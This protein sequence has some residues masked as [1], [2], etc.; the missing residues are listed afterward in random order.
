EDELIK[1]EEEIERLAVEAKQ[2]YGDKPEDTGRNQGGRL[3]DGSHD[4][5]VPLGLGAFDQSTDPHQDVADNDLDHQPQEDRDKKSDPLPVG[6][7]KQLV[8]GPVRYMLVAPCL[9]VV[10]PFE[11]ADIGPILDLVVDSLGV[12]DSIRRDEIFARPLA[13]IHVDDGDASAGQGPFAQ[14]GAVRDKVVAD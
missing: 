1:D 3:F 5:V 10:S 7:A 8:A 4:L 9:F 12:I 14:F 11:V 13:G 2:V 6:N